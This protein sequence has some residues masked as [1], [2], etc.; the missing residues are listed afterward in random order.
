MAVFTYRSLVKQE[1]PMKRKSHLLWLSLFLVFSDVSGVCA[2][3]SME[4][5]QYLEA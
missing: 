3:A 4:K 1:K 5:V 2:I